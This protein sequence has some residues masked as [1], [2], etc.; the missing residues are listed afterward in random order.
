MNTSNMHTASGK[1]SHIVSHQGSLKYTKT[2]WIKYLVAR[3]RKMGK[4]KLY[5]KRAALKQC[6][7]A[8]LSGL[9]VGLV[10]ISKS[11]ISELRGTK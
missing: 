2:E 8:N 4:C 6:F 3:R 5:F 7:C 9:K 10:I 1:R 11:S